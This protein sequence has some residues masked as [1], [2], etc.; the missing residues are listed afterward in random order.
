MENSKILIVEDEC[1]I[2]KDLQNMLKNIGYKLSY[3]AFSGKGAIDKVNKIQPDLVLMD[4][5]LKEDMD[6]IE[7]AEQI[8]SHF[9]IPII[10]ISALADEYT[11]ERAKKI[12]PYYFITKPV[13]ESR[14]K[15]AI[16]K[17]GL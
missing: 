9:D 16:E 14:L 7:T 3:I 8:L 1:V 13:S 5:K 12:K 15:E 6:G 11:L 10:F 4:V 2:A 17:T